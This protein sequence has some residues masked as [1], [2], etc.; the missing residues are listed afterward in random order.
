MK[1]TL[2]TILVVILL[3]LSLVVAQEDHENE[4]EEGKQLVK[5]GISCNDLTEEQLEA[6]GEYYMEQ[7]HPREAHEIMD[8]MMGGEGSES[9]RQVHINMAKRLYCNDKIYIG[10]G[11]MGGNMMGNGMMYNLIQP[12]MMNNYGYG[13]FNFLYMLLIIGLIVLVVLV[14][15]KLIKDLSKKK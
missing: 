15:I 8:E 3:S 1:K 13:Y 9:L 10:Y 5:G 6:I 14:I 2:F 12:G 4:I 7:M 11:M